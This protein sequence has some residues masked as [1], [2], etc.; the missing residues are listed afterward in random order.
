MIRNSQIRYPNADKHGLVVLKLGTI[1]DDSRGMTINARED[2]WGMT[3]EG[4]LGYVDQH[5]D[6]VTT[7][8]MIK[9]ACNK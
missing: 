8:Y 9:L 6:H 5:I 2:S 1:H 7:S 3:Y 4:L